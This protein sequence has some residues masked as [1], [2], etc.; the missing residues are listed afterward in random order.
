MGERLAFLATLGHTDG[1]ARGLQA[2]GTRE[3]GGSA[4]AKVAEARRVLRWLRARYDPGLARWVSQDPAGHE[5][6]TNLFRYVLNRRV[7]RVLC[8]LAS[9]DEA[10][11]A[12]FA[13]QRATFRFESGQTRASK[14]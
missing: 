7:P 13:D 5:A 1:L 12:R 6:G 4:G 11:G 10:T 2:L 3:V 9:A 14:Q 8:R